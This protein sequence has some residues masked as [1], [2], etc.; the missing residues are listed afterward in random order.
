MLVQKSS[1][2]DILGPHVPPVLGLVLEGPEHRAD[3]H[4]A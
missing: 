3:L 4:F 2:P 1:L